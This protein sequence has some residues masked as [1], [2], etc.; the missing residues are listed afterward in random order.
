V[1]ESI[2]FLKGERVVLRLPDKERD[3]ELFLQWFNDEEVMRFLWV[4]YPLTR[5]GEEEWFDRISES[6][7]DFVFVIE[8]TDSSIPIGVIGLH[9]IS[10]PDGTAVTGT[11]IGNQEYWGKGYGTDAKMLL[12]RYAFHTLGLRKIC[13]SVW[14][15]NERSHRYALKC[16]YHEEA[17][18]KDQVFKDGEYHDEILMAVYRQ[19]WEKVW[20]EYKNQTS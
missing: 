16:G 8:T 2:V 10:Y 18:R 12:L 19:D 1:S 14:A 17:R 5:K 7:T 15:F 6:K 3:M 9:Q 20:E 13:S 4:R 11:T